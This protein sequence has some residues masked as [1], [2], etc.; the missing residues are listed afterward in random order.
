MTTDTTT[1]EANQPVEVVSPLTEIKAL[2]LPD[3]ALMTRGADSALR[4]ANNFVITTDDDYNLAGEE[5]QAVKAKLK[6]MEETRTSITGPMNKALDAINALFRGPRTALEA[7]EKAIKGNMLTYHNEKERIAAE[8]RQAQEA[9]A[10]AERARLAEEARQ[11]EQR[12]AAERKRIAD[13][14]AAAES[15]R[16]QEQERLAAE[17]EKAAAAGNAAAAEEA[18][19]KIEASRLQST[20]EAQQAEQ[21]QQEANARANEEAASI[22]AATAAASAPVTSIASVRAKGA[23]VKVTVDF[24]VTNL[25]SLVQHIATHPELI[26]LVTEDS[27]KLRAYVRGLGVNAK[28]PG[29]RV[30][31]KQSMS[32]R[33]A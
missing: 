29:V 6:R 15:A 12:A 26:N 24:E 2:T 30:F 27:I 1:T 18:A 4:M 23:S 8:A 16:K 7:A 22:I 5:L 13:E 33:A 19:R 3:V 21:R 11:V 28:L 32:S 14:A 17:A 31:E 25:L 20:L 9:A 10:A